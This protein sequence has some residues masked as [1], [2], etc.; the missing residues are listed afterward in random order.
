MEQQKIMMYMYTYLNYIQF[1]TK[2]VLLAGWDDNPLLQLSEI[3]SILWQISAEH[4]FEFWIAGIA[5][6]GSET[7]R[8]QV[9]EMVMK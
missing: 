1:R 7:T 5:G 4:L 8:S 3:V 2:P 6:K 9:R